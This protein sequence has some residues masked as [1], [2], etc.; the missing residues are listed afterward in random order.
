MTHTMNHELSAPPTVFES[1]EGNTYTI[2]LTRQGWELAF[3][4]EQ[5]E[6]FVRNLNL[7][8][9]DDATGLDIR[10]R[11]EQYTSLSALNIDMDA[12]TV[13]IDVMGDGERPYFTANDIWIGGPGVG[14]GFRTSSTRF[15][16]SNLRLSDLGLGMMVNNCIGDLA[17]PTIFGHFKYAGLLVNAGSSVVITEPHIDAQ[18]GLALAVESGSSVTIYG[19][20]IRG[21]IEVDDDCTLQMIGVDAP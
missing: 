16:I 5:G 11:G 7:L 18:E 19:G 3:L 13:A 9:N 1:I 21:D 8:I 17:A 20:R 10:L 6:Y 12:E 14:T 4:D 2:E 15:S